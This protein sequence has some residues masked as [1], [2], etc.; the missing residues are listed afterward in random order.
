MALGAENTWQCGIV[1]GHNRT[2]GTGRI[3]LNT[4]HGTNGITITDG[5]EIAEL[6]RAKNMG[7]MSKLGLHARE[8]GYSEYPRR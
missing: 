3:Y 2:S 8:H 1:I 5:E 4:D 7:A 6:E